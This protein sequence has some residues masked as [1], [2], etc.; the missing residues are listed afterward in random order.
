MKKITKMSLLAAAT[1]EAHGGI[2]KQDFTSVF[3]RSM[4]SARA[5]MKEKRLE[6]KRNKTVSKQRRH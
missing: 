3:G 6:Y 5:L 1:I 2:G 4:D